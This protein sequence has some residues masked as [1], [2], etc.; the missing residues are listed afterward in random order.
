MRFHP[1]RKWRFDFCDTIS[2]VA[3]EIEGGVFGRGRHTT[4]TGFTEDCIK[5]LEANLL[6]WTVIRLTTGMITYANCQRVAEFI[7]KRQAG[8]TIA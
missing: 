6:G 4:G 2:R 8:Q 3:I 7:K 1:T 5:Y